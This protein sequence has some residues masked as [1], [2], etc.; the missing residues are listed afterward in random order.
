MK[1][2]TIRIGLARITHG[3]LMA[4]ENPSIRQ[5]CETDLYIKHIIADYRKYAL[6]RIKHRISHN[7][8]ATLGPNHQHNLVLIMFLKKTNF[9]NNI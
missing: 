8:D 6:N 2:I 1:L 9:Y 4:K 7:L 3:L 5:A